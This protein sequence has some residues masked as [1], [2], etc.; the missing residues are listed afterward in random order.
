MTEKE[1][2]DWVYS[3][4]EDEKSRLIFTARKKLAINNEDKYIDELVSNSTGGVGSRWYPEKKEELVK[5]LRERNQNIIIYG[6]GYFGKQVLELCTQGGLSVDFFCDTDAG[7]W[8]SQIQGVAIISP[9]KLCGMKE[10]YAIVVSPKYAYAEIV[11]KLIALGIDSNNIYKYVDYAIVSSEEQYFDQDIVR[12]EDGEVF[13]DGGCLDLRTSK[14]F[15]NKMKERGFSVERIYAFEPDEINYQKCLERLSNSD[16][17]K[18]DVIK[19]GLW[20]TDGYANFSAEG[21]GGSHIILQGGG[22]Y[23]N[24]YF[25]CYS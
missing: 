4:L 8:G 3:N 10:D 19:A 13:V 7:R 1:K 2:V 15:S 22:V 21:T 12:L 20:S 25:R 17:G 18:L 6:A 24:S 9:D 14:I 23:R 11:N 16:L 5:I